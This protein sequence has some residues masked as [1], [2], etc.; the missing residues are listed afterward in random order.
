MIDEMQN[1]EMIEQ[2]DLHKSLRSSFGLCH[3][4]NRFF[5]IYKTILCILKEKER[6]RDTAKTNALP[7]KNIEI[8]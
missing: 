7:Q 4:I 3:Q 2:T 5:F 1:M 8:D 6:M